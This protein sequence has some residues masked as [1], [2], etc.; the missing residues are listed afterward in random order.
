MK[1]LQMDSLAA[2]DLDCVQKR[3]ARLFFLSQE[4]EENGLVN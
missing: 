2:S 1:V 4:E 3:T